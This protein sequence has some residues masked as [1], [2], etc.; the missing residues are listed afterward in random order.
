MALTAHS[1][2]TPILGVDIWEHVSTNL[3]FLDLLAYRYSKAFYLQV[4]TD[5]Q[6]PILC[7]PYLMQSTTTSKLM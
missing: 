4:S 1:A 3:P 2:H 7:H 6:H 5:D